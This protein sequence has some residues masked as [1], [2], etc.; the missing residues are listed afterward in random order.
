M[1][2]TFGLMIKMKRKDT[3]SAQC[4]PWAIGSGLERLKPCLQR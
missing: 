2:Y 1:K 4:R 3:V